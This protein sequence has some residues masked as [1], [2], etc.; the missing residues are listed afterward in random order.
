MT[1][2]LSTNAAIR[3]GSSMNISTAG[4][5]TIISGTSTASTS[6]VTSDGPGRTLRNGFNFMFSPGHEKGLI[7][8]PTVKE[9]FGE[10]VCR[11]LLVLRGDVIDHGIEVCHDLVLRFFGNEAADGAFAQA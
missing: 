4:W 10:T 6:M 2:F 11:L 5:V 1:V 8:N 9:G 7:G 3:S